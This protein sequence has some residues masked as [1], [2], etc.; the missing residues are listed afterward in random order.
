M[1]ESTDIL[2]S[3]FA[4]LIGGEALL[5]VLHR[6]SGRRHF[7]TIAGEL[8]PAGGGLFLRWFGFKAVI[9]STP[10]VRTP[11]KAAGRCRIAVFGGSAAAGCN[12]E[13]S[14]SEILGADL[15]R[16]YPHLD[17]YI[18]NFAMNSV[19]FHRCQAEIL[20]AVF[21]RYDVFLIYT[22]NN[23]GT[24]FHND[25]G[26]W[27]GGT[28]PDNRFPE[29]QTE[30]ILELEARAERF[31]SLD[32]VID[33]LERRSRLF[34]LATRFP[35]W[36]APQQ[37]RPAGRKLSPLVR[38][39]E[40]VDQPIIPHDEMDRIEER[41][42][43]DMEAIADMADALGKPVLYSSVPTNE[44]FKPFFSTFSAQTTP[45]QRQAI[46]TLV[47]EA[48]ASSE[49]ALALE[50][51]RK[52]EAIDGHV[53]IVNHEAG[54]CLEALGRIGEARSYFRRSIDWEAFY[55]RAPARLHDRARAVADRHRHFHFIDGIETAHRALDDG[56]AWCDLIRDVNHPT[57]LGHA[58]LARSFFA[59]LLEEG[60]LERFGV[61]ANPHPPD[62]EPVREALP[63]Y[64][65]VLGVDD[66]LRS[67]SRFAVARWLI[68]LSECTAYPQ[69][70]LDAAEPCL[71]TSFEFSAGGAVDGARFKLFTALVNLKRGDRRRACDLANEALATHRRF[72]ISTMTGK[73]RFPS[74]LPL[75][76]VAGLFRDY[77]VSF[78]DNNGFTPEQ[79]D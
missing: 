71:E 56:L 76:S 10:H 18:A 13:R 43:A 79:A 36:V 21:A 74:L 24:I 34:A 41:F 57:M 54:R 49:P 50:A 53:A 72:V 11:G 37:G 38:P 9:A 32:T 68:G 62:L 15:R 65:K 19:P 5:L 30:R 29:E 17:F 78:S 63:A 61:T 47:A 64:E 46:K 14:F 59:R 66:R 60:V 51:Y 1:V 70:F 58:V 55:F 75:G 33:F 16:H 23:E 42:A 35:Q 77:R 12:A 2:L 25:A 39:Q 8:A 4:V 73:G 27:T 45:D 7:N 26:L 40:F 6:A 22:G 69:D 52:A 31:F 67:E 20:E 48:R 28:R 3:L 44:S